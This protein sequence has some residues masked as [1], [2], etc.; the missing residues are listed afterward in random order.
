MAGSFVDVEGAAADAGSEGGASE[1]AEWSEERRQKYQTQLIGYR[2]ELNQLYAL[3]KTKQSMT[4]ASERRKE[5]SSFIKGT[6]TKDINQILAE[7]VHPSGKGGADIVS[8]INEIE[9]AILKQDVIDALVNQRQSVYD[10][11][12]TDQQKFKEISIKA[13]RTIYALQTE[14]TG[15]TEEIGIT[16]AEGGFVKM[17]HISM[18]TFLQEMTDNIS[19]SKVAALDVTSGDPWKLN[20][21]FNSSVLAKLKTL[22]QQEGKQVLKLTTEHKFFNDLMLRQDDNYSVMQS[23]FVAEAL[24]RANILGQ[25]YQYAQDNLAWYKGSDIQGLDK[26]GNQVSISM[27][28]A[29]FGSPTLLRINSLHTALNKIIDGLKLT[30]RKNTPEK[31]ASFIRQ[32]IYSGIGGL[33]NAVSSYIEQNLDFG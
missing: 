28:N 9:D 17:I 16:F 29:M 25:K 31:V 6:L 18:D 33:N 12:D 15:V 8:K 4:T 2:D 7:Q 5:M 10:I 14:L 20:L 32:R 23:G 3:S 24:A 22:S 27:K 1:F 30:Q 11:A 13:M 21:N 19:L 26:Y